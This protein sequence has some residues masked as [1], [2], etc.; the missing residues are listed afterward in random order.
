MR[1]KSQRSRQPLSRPAMQQ[2]EVGERQQLERHPQEP[3]VDKFEAMLL[4]A[5]E[6]WSANRGRQGLQLQPIRRVQRRL[7]PRTA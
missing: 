3:S 2:S 6:A 1:V 7:L 4:K 5:R